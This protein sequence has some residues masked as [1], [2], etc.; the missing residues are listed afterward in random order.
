MWKCFDLGAQCPINWMWD[1][2]KKTNRVLAAHKTMKNKS[3]KGKCRLAALSKS[4]MVLHTW[5]MYGLKKESLLFF[6]VHPMT[7]RQIDSLLGNPGNPQLTDLEEYPKLFYSAPSQS[8]GLISIALPLALV[9]STHFWIMP[10]PQYPLP[11]MYTAAGDG[12]LS[13]LPEMVMTRYW[14]TLPRFRSLENIKKT[15]THADT[16]CPLRTFYQSCL[17][18]KS[19]AHSVI[20]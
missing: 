13:S 3:R 11:W 5:E 16:M 1:G 17:F 8:L 12:S 18:W 14:Y 7:C 15:I 20:R 10:S 2:M 19:H 4:F 9:R 6:W